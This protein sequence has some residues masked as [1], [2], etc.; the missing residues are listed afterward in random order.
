MKNF[1][2][3][4][5]VLLTVAV[6]ILFALHFSGKAGKRAGTAPTAAE[7]AATTQLRIA[8]FYSDS[9]MEHYELFK[10][11]RTAMEQEMKN[12]RN[13]LAAGQREFEKQ[14]AEFQ[15]RAQ[16]LTITEKEAKEQRL[17]QQQQQLLQDEQRLSG[18][19]AEKNA[20]VNK[21]IVETIEAF[22]KEYAA[23][24]NFT[25]ILSYTQGESLWFADPQL[26]ITADILKELNQRYKNKKAE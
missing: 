23:E 14:V 7:A 19:L 9:I 8:F 3:V 21:R 26:D 5:N 18:E 13:K 2:L 12:A 10:E 1:S 6:V 20:G 22:L 11:E 4:F 24:N 16:Y 15:Q 25:Y 17:Y